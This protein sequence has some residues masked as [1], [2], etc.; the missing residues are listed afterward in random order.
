MPLVSNVK[1]SFNKT[2]ILE[3]KNIII[4][5]GN[6]IGGNLQGLKKFNLKSK[7]TPGKF[8]TQWK[9]ILELSESIECK[10]S[11]ASLH[12]F[13]KTSGITFSINSAPS[14]LNVSIRSHFI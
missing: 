1:T 7:L 9:L 12:E 6:T 10:L 4:L 14:I 3:F 8:I 13:I 2:N 5:L 11:E